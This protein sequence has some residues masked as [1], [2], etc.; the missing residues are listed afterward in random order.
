[1]P[2]SIPARKIFSVS[3]FW[4]Y[5][6]L[7]LYLSLSSL[8]GGLNLS[9]KE[10][11]DM[12]LDYIF[13]FLAY[14]LFF[15]LYI[16]LDYVGYPPFRSRPLLWLIIVTLLLG[17]GTE[18]LQG[19]SSTRTFSLFDLLANCTGVAFGIILFLLRP[20]VLRI[21]FPSGRH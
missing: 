18:F 9:K 19:F 10:I 15:C 20:Y 11:L 12:R 2:D 4:G 7:I 16:I 3:V 13:H 1:M 5:Y 8:I 14:L 6:L 21:K 17:A